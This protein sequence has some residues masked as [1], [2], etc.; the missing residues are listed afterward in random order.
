MAAFSKRRILNFQ[1]S[2]VRTY[3]SF[4]RLQLDDGFA[5][6]Q[7]L[8]ALFEGFGHGVDLLVL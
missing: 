1:P 8:Y 5:V 2:G 4:A 3:S 7:C 6:F